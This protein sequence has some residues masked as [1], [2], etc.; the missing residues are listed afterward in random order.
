[1]LDKLSKVVGYKIYKIS[2]YT[3]IH[4]TRSKPNHSLN[5]QRIVD[6]NLKQ[7]LALQSKD[8]KEMRKETPYVSHSVMSDSL[9][10][11]GL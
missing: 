5:I 7:P 6:K 8:H 2:Y 10:L 9:Q 11:H 1:M 4:K 3:H